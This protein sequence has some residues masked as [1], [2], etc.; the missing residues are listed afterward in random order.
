MLT[1]FTDMLSLVAVETLLTVSEV[2][3]VLRAV[4][5]L[6]ALTPRGLRYYARA[7]DSYSVGDVHRRDRDSGR[8]IPTS[9]SGAL[10]RSG[11][12]LGSRCGGTGDAMTQHDQQ[13]LVYST[14]AAIE[15]LV[16]KRHH[17]ALTKHLAAL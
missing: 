3:R 7:A 17:E 2:S 5:G 14:F 1:L 4:E 8:R 13:A 9:E 12:G 11:V 16:S 15:R 10:D 6:A